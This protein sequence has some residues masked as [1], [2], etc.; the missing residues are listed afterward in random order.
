MSASFTVSL[1]NGAHFSAA[2]DENLLTAAQRSNWMV[3]YGCR[4]GNCEACAATLLQGSVLQRGM[5]IDAPARQIF[6]CLCSAQ[7]DLQIA[8]PSDPRA[9][10]IDQAQRRY[11]RLREQIIT[12]TASTFYFAL[13]AGRKPALLSEQFAVLETDQGLLQ[14]P[15]DIDK[16]SARELVATLAAS[17]RL[18]VGAYY[19]LR[20]PLN[21]LD[22]QQISTREFNSP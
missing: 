9:G 8:L 16:S 22:A 20:Y 21:A 14:M 1:V 3:R 5:T 15:I 4:N 6:L 2:D 17:T 19:Y 11:V 10:S 13:P 18:Q 12:A 7:S